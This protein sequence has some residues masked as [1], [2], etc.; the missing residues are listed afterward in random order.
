MPE[1]MVPEVSM[2]EVMVRSL[3]RAGAGGLRLSI[4][5][6]ADRSALPQA[7]L[8]GLVPPAEGGRRP[9]V[10]VMPGINV[11]ADSY[12]WLA[13]ELTLAGCVV[14]AYSLIGDLGP[15][16]EGITPGIDLEA[17]T[18]AALGKRPSASALAEVLD[19]IGAEPIL[20]G[21]ADMKRI[22]LG[23]HSAGGTLALHN[24]RPAWFPGVCAAFSYAGHTMTAASLGHGES[25]VAPVPSETP[26]LLLSGALDGVIAASRDRYITD[27]A[28]PHDPMRRTFEE[29]VVSDRGDCWWVELAEGTHFTPCHPVD[30][31]SARS[32]LEPPEPLQPPVPSDPPVPPE[33]PD[34]PGMTEARN[35]LVQLLVAFLRE[36]VLDEGD[37]RLS[38]SGLVELPGVSNWARR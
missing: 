11:V 28:T 27:P 2:P 6:L 19:L 4:F 21:V 14:A 25:P 15:A 13:Q 36:Y 1:V 34:P 5:Y 35:L 24:A 22:V 7:R 10:V 3:H 30:H 29:A 37:R 31:T 38:L 32:F 20:S 26:L 8:T 23:G 9:V 16:G 33:L 17:L 18:P 12:R